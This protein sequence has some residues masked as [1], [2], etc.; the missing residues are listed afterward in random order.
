MP[1]RALIWCVEALLTAGA[2][3][4]LSAC[5]MVAIGYQ[6]APT[7]VHWRLDQ[8]LDFDSAQSADVRARL[9]RLHAWHRRSELGD[10]ARLLG[11]VQ[12][13]IG[14]SV[15]VED[16]TWLHDEIRR[17]YTRIL[18]AAATD[19][20]EVVLGLRPD[21]IDVL[22]GRLGRMRGDF[23]RDRVDVGAERARED[24]YRHALKTLERW[25]GA[26]DDGA[27]A[28]LRRLADDIPLDTRLELE[29]LRR[30]HGELLALLRSVTAGKLTARE[31]IAERLKRS[32]GRWEEGR[33]P[34]YA[35]YAARSRTALHRF[36]AEAASLTTPAQRER[37]RRELQRYIDDIAAL[38]APRTSAR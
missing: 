26:F 1:N 17:R 22:E 31:E 23:T 24:T 14:R 7:F 13:R 20:V 35:Q 29:D 21:Q 11:E 2:A 19:A 33:T 6:S 5:S 37:A 32:F 27:R 16:V 28:R 34:E 8:A 3:L 10:Y 18:E 36:Y 9:A 30:R 15:S 38:A 12:V 25:Y 4:L